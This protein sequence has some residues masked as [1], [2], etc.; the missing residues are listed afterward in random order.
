MPASPVLAIWCMDWPA[1]AAAAAAGQPATA[2]VAVSL[3]TRPMPEGC[4]HHR[5]E[6]RTSLAQR[7][8]RARPD[9]ALQRLAVHE[10]RVDP[11]R[12][13]EDREERA[14]FVPGRKFAQKKPVFL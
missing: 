10:P 11:C 8:E 14:A 9:Q 6:L 4:I 3:D 2:P 7:I 5:V 13:V 1:V 12:E